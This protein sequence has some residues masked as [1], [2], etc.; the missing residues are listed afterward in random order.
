MYAGVVKSRWLK[1]DRHIADPLNLIIIIIE[2]RLPQIAIKKTVEKCGNVL[3][4]RTQRWQ[5]GYE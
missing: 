4:E 5:D 1:R 2:V 3:K